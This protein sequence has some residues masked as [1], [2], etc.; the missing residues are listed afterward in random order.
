M[1]HLSLIILSKGIFGRK[2]LRGKYVSL[3]RSVQCQ[4]H[5]SYKIR[6]S[7]DVIY[8]MHV[9]ILILVVDFASTDIYATKII[10][11]QVVKFTEKER[12]CFQNS[13]FFFWLVI[14]FIKIYHSVLDLYG[15]CFPS[16]YFCLPLSVSFYQPFTHFHSSIPEVT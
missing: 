1:I 3:F 8:F 6:Y 14:L 12:N 2:I 9:R 10:L 7:F 13:S 4:T 11:T 5:V 15:S 16:M